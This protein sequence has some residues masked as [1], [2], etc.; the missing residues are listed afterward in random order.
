MATIVN[1]PT[2]VPANP[3]AIT[4]TEWNTFIN[5]VNFINGQLNVGL[6]VLP[7]AIPYVHL[8]LPQ[9]FINNPGNAT[10]RLVAANATI[11]HLHRIHLQLILARHQLALTQ[12]QAQQ[13]GQPAPAPVT[14][15]PTDPRIKATTPTK[16]GGK[17]QHAQTFIAE[18]NNYFALVPMIDIQQIWFAL[19][20]IDKDGAGWKCNQLGL[21]SQVIPPAHLATWAAFV[22]EF[23]TRFADPEEQKK[24]T[25]LL[26]HGKV[27]QTTSVHTF[28]DLVQEKCDLAHYD[29][30]DMCMDIIKA[31]LKPDLAQVLTGQTFVGYANFTRTLI[32]TD[33]AL[34]QLCVKEGKQTFRTSNATALGSGS[35]KTNKDKPHVDNSKYKLTDEEK[36]EHMDG[37]LCGE[38]WQ[39]AEG[40]QGAVMS[41]KVR[42]GIAHH[43]GLLFI[44][45]LVVCIYKHGSQIIAQHYIVKWS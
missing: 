30:M 8:A 20:L 15:P 12:A 37:H 14:P 1:I 34:Q 45:F 18:C 33:K 11:T 3:M 36:K 43:S 24:A 31:R 44:L 13:A 10:A 38:N 25:A 27:I 22:A 40:W 29:D 16:Y 39:V 21:I 7:S 6:T 2:F 5:K 28:I 9:A 32:V 4:G 35:S 19:Q 26:N 23:N 42:M 17:T 41:S